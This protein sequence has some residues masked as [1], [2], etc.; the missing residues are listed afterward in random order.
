MFDRDLIPKRNN[1]GFM[2]YNLKYVPNLCLVFIYR[3]TGYNFYHKI[4]NNEK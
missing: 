1:S 2:Q 3:L 4:R